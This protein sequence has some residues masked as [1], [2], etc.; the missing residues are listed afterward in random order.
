MLNSKKKKEVKPKTVEDVRNELK[1]KV[2][3]SL[4]DKI[5]YYESIGKDLDYSFNKVVSQIGDIN[6]YINSLVKKG[7]AQKTISNKKLICN[8]IFEFAVLKDYIEY[9]F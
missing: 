6:E 4:L 8:K 7:Y 1:E 9:M 3:L 5:L 2:V